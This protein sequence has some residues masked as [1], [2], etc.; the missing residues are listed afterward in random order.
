MVSIGIIKAIR[1][2][3]VAFTVSASKRGKASSLQLANEYLI[4]RQLLLFISPQMPTCGIAADKVKRHGRLS[5]PIV[6]L[7]ENSL[8]MSTSRA[9]P[10][11]SAWECWVIRQARYSLCFFTKNA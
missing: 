11:R 7:E 3:K 10:L 8:C 1:P 6:G 9:R 5:A 2:Q 4:R